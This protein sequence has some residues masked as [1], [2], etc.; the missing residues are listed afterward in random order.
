MFLNDVFFLLVS[1]FVGLTVRRSAFWVD[2]SSLGGFCLFLFVS[3]L[4]LDCFLSFSFLQRAAFSERRSVL[5]KFV[6]ETK[7]AVS[8]DRLRS[9]FES[10]LSQRSSLP[11]PLGTASCLELASPTDVLRFLHDRDSR[12]RTAVHSFD[13]PHFGLAGKFD[14]LCVRHLA[15]GTVDSYVGQIRAAFNH[16]GRVDK[17]SPDNPRAN[18][19]DSH[20]VK[21]WVRA[22]EK[23]QRRHR[24]PVSQSRPTFSV[25][26]RLLVMA[27]GVR[28]ASLSPPPPLFPDRF[29]LL[30]D[31]CFFLIQWFCGDRAGDLGNALGKEV[32]RLECG[33]LLFNHTVGKQIRQSE[34]QLLVVP[35]V[36]EDPELCPVAAFEVYTSAC[37]SGGLD[38]RL[39]F[40][41]PPTV[42]P[43]HLSVRDAPFTS[44]AATKRLRLYLP[45]EGLTAH[46][47]R[48]GCA[49]TLSMLGASQEAV[50]EHCRWATARVC[51]HYTKIEKIRRLD[52]SARLL[53]NAVTS[54]SSD[55]PSDADSAALLYDLLNSGLHQESAL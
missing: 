45:D 14:C 28:L 16:I 26:L 55:V 48:A 11:P 22:C 42:A 27:I 29:L 35:P 44:S 24:V 50:M 40:L 7:Y 18:P 10:F 30:R 39:G 6:C 46:G 53:Q 25:H 54:S 8:K 52:S 5:S 49:I 36:P 2:L 34:G 21:D 51:R 47:S 1:R 23:E 9:D 32:V 12:G 20:L 19:C 3:V 41:F 13:C 33:S 4:C 43:R 38:L 17:Y 37:V 31:R 15:A